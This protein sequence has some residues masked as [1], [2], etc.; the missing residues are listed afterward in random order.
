MKSHAEKIRSHIREVK[1]GTIFLADD[2]GMG[3]RQAVR[4]IL[5]RLVKDNSIVRLGSGIYMK[6]RYNKL[7]GS[8]EYPSVDEIAHAVAQKEKAR[9]VP[10]GAHA[11]NWL[12]L[13]TQVPMRSVFLTD[14]SPRKITLEDGRTIVFKRTTA[15]NL[16]YENNIVRS[17]VSA[18]KEIGEQGID[19]SIRNTLAAILAP[20]H[21]DELKHDIPLAPEWIQKELKE[22]LSRSKDKE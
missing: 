1:S 21:A 8:L 9:I 12:G 16:S 4:V 6:P 18:L 19:E 11:V 20:V 14:G 5:S 22:I 17:V 2:F 10:S 7:L 15:R 3:D 13:S